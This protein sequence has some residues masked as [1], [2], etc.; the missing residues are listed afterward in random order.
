[1]EHPYTNDLVNETSPY[2]LQHAHNPVD[3]KPWNESVLQQAKQ[4]GKPLLISIGYAACHWCHVMEHESFEDPLVAKVMNEHFINIKVDREERPDVDQ[5]YM[6]AVQLMRGNG[7]W[8]LNIVALP[9]G[10]PFWGATYLPKQQW[11]RNLEELIKIYQT[12]RERIVEYADKLQQGMQ[13]VEQVIPNTS[14]P[15]FSNEEVRIAVESW[16]TYFD[17]RL[18]G[19]NRAPKFMMPNNYDFLLRWAH[20]T[21]DSALNQ[22]VLLTLNKMAYGGIYDHVGGG[23]S[24]YSVDT[25][26]HVPHF[27][28]MLYDNAQLVS[29]YSHAYQ[30]T[31]DPLYKKV[32]FETIAFVERELMHT[33]GAFYSSLD[34]DSLDEQGQLEE[35]A[36][37]VWKEDVLKELLKDDFKIF[38]DYY[39]INEYGLWEDGNY[40][41]IRD[42]DA[43]SVAKLHNMH[44]EKLESSINR[45]KEIL[46]KERSNRPRPR[47]DDKSLTSWNALMIQGYLDAY[48]AF[49]E[50]PF[51]QAALK[52]ADFILNNQLKKD[53]S[54]YHSYKDGKSTI[55][56]YLEDYSTT[57]SAFVSLFEATADEKWLST[58]KSLTTYAYVNFYDQDSQLFFFT[59]N[60]D[61]SLVTRN[62]EKSDNVIP[63]SNSMLAKALFKLGHIY[64]EKKYLKTSQQM[65]NNMKDDVLKFGSSHSNWLDLMLSFS[66]DY[67]EVA[68]VGSEALYMAKDLQKD[69]LPNKVVIASLGESNVP[70][71]ENRLADGETLIYVCVNGTCK[72]PVDTVEK[73]TSLLG[74]AN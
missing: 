10:R 46:F 53:G 38:K 22:Y 48:N 42:K 19:I 54:L 37:Y 41:L 44:I 18:G 2:L 27:E 30:K 12:D 11:T 49:G 32:V 71:L 7:G 65:L 62:I 70:L 5:V 14:E 33:N 9:D 59:S 35:G 64:G 15:A 34:A 43:E 13:A 40:V 74:A 4:E 29:L 45:C 16:S 8:P 50:R 23:F 39:N 20:Q 66:E 72:L 58:A 68:I 31:N 73:A 60:E 56:G 52:N 24:R 61:T 3:W 26:W 63:A 67:Y 17:Q 1:M 25:K 6:N 51:L 55:N 47:L 28:K 36:F 57:I 69:Y 21:D